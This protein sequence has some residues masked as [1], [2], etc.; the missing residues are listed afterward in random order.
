[1]IRVADRDGLVQ[2]LRVAGIGT[3]IYYPVSMHHQDCFA[4]RCRKAGSLLESESAARSVLAL[5]IYPE[6]TL[7]QLNFVADTVLRSTSTLEN[8]Q[9]S[10]QIH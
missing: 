3:E 10:V 5:P 1:M 7:E 9:L 6:L 2:S 8:Q 4:G